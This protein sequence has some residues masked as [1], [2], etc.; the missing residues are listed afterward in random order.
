MCISEAEYIEKAQKLARLTVKGVVTAEEYANNV[1]EYCALLPEFNPH[2]VAIVAKS[3]PTMAHDALIG[4]TARILHP[5]YEYPTVHFGGPGP[6]AA[7]RERIRQI[8]GNRIHAFAAALLEVL[9][10][11]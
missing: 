11:A 6:S 9:Q 2:T 3:V 4:V 10:T 1:L 5:D 8:H 7:E